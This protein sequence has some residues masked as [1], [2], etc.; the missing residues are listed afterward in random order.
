MIKVEYDK[1][2]EEMETVIEG[3]ANIVLNEYKELT[4]KIFEALSKITE[5]DEAKK[6]V[7]KAYKLGLK[8]AKEKEGKEND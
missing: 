1:K 2:T 6:I 8:E 4:K 3:D 5:E 7:K